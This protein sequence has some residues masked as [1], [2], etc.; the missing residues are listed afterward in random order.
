MNLSVVGYGHTLCGADW[1]F[2]TEGESFH[3]VYYVLGGTCRCHLN[4]KT[5]TLQKGTLYLLPRH[6]P[7]AMEHDISDPFYVLWQHVRISDRDMDREMAAIP[8]ERESAAGH[9]LQAME[10]LSEGKLVESVHWADDP[11][12]LQLQQLCGALF[13]ILEQDHMIFRA[14]DQRLSEIFRM[15]SEHPEQRYTV[16]Q[17]AALAKLERSHFSRIFHQQFHISAQ[18]FLI[19]IRLEQGARALLRGESVGESAAISGYQD[20]KAFIRAFSSQ[21]GMSPSKYKKHHIMQP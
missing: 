21:Y 1:G 15:V 17:L 12:A 11:L 7:Y 18:R 5:T 6:T 20:T 13:A 4:G 16:A 14:V 19:R 8:V 9:V 10:L 3:R 2:S